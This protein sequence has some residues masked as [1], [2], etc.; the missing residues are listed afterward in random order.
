MHARLPMHFGP[1]AVVLALGVAACGGSSGDEEKVEKTLNR[2]YDA[3]AAKD[4]DKVCDSLSEE[5][6]RELT[7]GSGTAGGKAQDCETVLRFGLAFAGDALKGIED[8]QVKDVR[9][10]GSEATA[11]VK[12]KSREGGVKLVKEDGDWKLQSF[13]VGRR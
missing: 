12:Y 6:K 4:G 1:V 5:G 3:L 9:V 7:K 10:D 13:D 11:T 2:V 8:A